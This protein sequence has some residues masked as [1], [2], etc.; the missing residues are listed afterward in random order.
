MGTIN[1]GKVVVGGLA[2]GLLINIS[3]FV[4]NGVVMAKE[5][6]AMTAR[7]NLPP[8]GGGAYA[9]F[10][11]LGFVMGVALV[12]VYAAMRPR[13]G[14]GPTTALTAGAAVWFFAYFYPTVGFVAMGMFPL[15]AATLAAVWGLGEMLIAAYVGGALYKE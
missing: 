7:M 2:A 13:F 10:T 14:A 15:G 6:E 8:M 11:V 12:W 4:L 9:A 5:M 3:E 1:T